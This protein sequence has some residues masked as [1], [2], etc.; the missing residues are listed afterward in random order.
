MEK[1]LA[2]RAAVASMQDQAGSYPITSVLRTTALHKEARVHSVS[3]MVRCPSK[4]PTRQEG[5]EIQ[6]N[7]SMEIMMKIDLSKKECGPRSTRSRLSRTSKRVEE[8][9]EEEE[10]EEDD[11]GEEAREEEDEDEGDEG[12]EEEEDREEEEE[13]D[14]E[15]EDE[16]EV[17]K[18]KGEEDEDE[19]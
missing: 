6:D 2:T 13:E 4:E 12:E 1:C 7:H 5:E 11:E 10:D 8:G 18:M 15:D 3:D 17:K 9:E 19:E 14:E 16:D